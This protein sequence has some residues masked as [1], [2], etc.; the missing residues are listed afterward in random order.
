MAANSTSSSSLLGLVDHAGI[1]LGLHAEMQ[2]QRGVAAVV[3][4][5]VRPAAIRPFENAVGVI[6]VVFKRLAL[7]REHRRAA[8][9]DRGGGVILRRVDVARGPAQVGAE[10]FERLDQHRGLDRHVQ[11]AGD[12][13]PAQR[14]AGAELFARRHQAGHFGLGDGDFLS[15]PFGQPDVLDD[16]I[17]GC[18]VGFR[19]GRGAHNDPSGRDYWMSR[20]ALAGRRRGGNKHIKIPLCLIRPNWPTAQA[21]HHRAAVGGCC[22]PRTRPS[23]RARISGISSPT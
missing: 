17:A 18:G 22:T 11:R 8:G 4:D 16:I 14:L 7:D 6:P 3:E 10:R 21:C 5:H 23:N 20:A 13:R 1:A 15:A 2:Q 12:A 19:L 9:G